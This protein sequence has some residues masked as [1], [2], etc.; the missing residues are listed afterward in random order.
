M[1]SGYSCCHRNRHKRESC[2]TFGERNQLHQTE[3]RE[4][5]KK[6]VPLFT[7]VIIYVILQIHGEV[8]HPDLK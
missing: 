7:P 4:E 3:E 6:T 2:I 8:D 5:E 1:L